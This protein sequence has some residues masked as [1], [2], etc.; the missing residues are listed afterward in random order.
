MTEQIN[1]GKQLESFN[2]RKKD[3]QKEQVII[4]N[5]ILVLVFVFLAALSILSNKKLPMNDFI[6]LL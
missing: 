5:M 2:K 1:Y 4:D 3:L 6:K